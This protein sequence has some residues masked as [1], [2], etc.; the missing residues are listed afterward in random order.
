MGIKLEAS[1]GD[2][3]IAEA[4]DLIEQQ[5]EHEVPL[6]NF[7]EDDLSVDGPE[8][9]VLLAIELEN[10]TAMGVAIQA[11]V[12]Y[13]LILAELQYRSGHEFQTSV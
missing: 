8:N 3:Q 11:S 2:P 7:A 4:H 12:E 6:D 9:A 13:G 5:R 10:A 1:Y